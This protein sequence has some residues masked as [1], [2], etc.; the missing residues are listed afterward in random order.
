VFA[1]G[2]EGKLDE[3]AVFDYALSVDEIATFWEV[4][5]I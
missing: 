1:D 4:S 5:G 3:F 2:L